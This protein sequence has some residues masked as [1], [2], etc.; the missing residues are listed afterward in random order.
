QGDLLARG[1]LD[2]AAAAG[3]PLAAVLVAVAKKDDVALRAAA[4]RGEPDALPALLVR[5]CALDD[6]PALVR[7]GDSV[8]DADPL[9]AERDYLRADALGEPAART[10]IE[11]LVALYERGVAGV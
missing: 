1:E 9:A 4:A 2:A 3:D 5:A 7:H 6:P 10:A 8:L 11:R